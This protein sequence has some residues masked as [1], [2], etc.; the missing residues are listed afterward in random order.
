MRN[1]I[2]LRFIGAREHLPEILRKRIA[3]AEAKTAA[4]TP[5]DTGPRR[6]LWRPLGHRAGDAP[7]RRQG[8]RRRPRSR[9]TSTSRVLGR[10]MALAGLPAPD[11]LIRTGGEQRVSNFL[12]W[13]LAYTELYFTDTLWPDFGAPEL[14]E[15]IGL[16]PQPPASV[17][18]HRRP[19][20]GAR[21]TDR[22][23]RRGRMRTHPARWPRTHW[24]NGFSRPSCW[25]AVLL[26]A[27][28]LLPEGIRIGLIALFVLGAAW[29]WSAFLG[30]QSRPGASAL[31]RAGR[32][33][34][35][36]AHR[37]PRVPAVCR[38]H[39]SR[40]PAWL[41]WVAGV[42]ADPAIPGS[43]LAVAA[44]LAAGFLVLVPAWVSPGRAALHGDR[45]ANPAAV[46][47]RHRLG[48]RRRCVLRRAAASG[49]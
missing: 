7:G 32:H 28:L 13:D 2:Q 33:A 29:E 10:H 6:G 37:L 24:R 14:D 15:A 25:S 9:R 43:A 48:G 36:A 5:H 42:R 4:N 49:A 11:L 41:W 8:S 34:A 44:T 39:R 18:P 45:W 12:L 19:A 35:H 26:P 31:R 20:R 17:R 23:S 46:R 21:R 38:R 22:R 3:A 16:L 1:G 27:F 30:L 47:A 40:R